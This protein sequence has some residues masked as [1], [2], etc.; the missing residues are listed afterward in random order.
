[1][2]KI[3]LGF[4]K[5]TNT[6]LLLFADNVVLKIS[7]QNNFP[8]IYPDV[9]TGIKARD[10]F[11]DAL[12]AAQNGGRLEIAN[13]NLKRKELEKVLKLWGSHIEDVSNGNEI[14]ILDAG[15]FV[16]QTS[17]AGKSP[18]PPQNVRL[19]DG[20]LQGD[21][22]A[23]CKKVSN[24][25]SYELRHRQANETEWTIAPIA[26]KTTIELK[27]VAAPGTIIWVQ[28]RAS[29]SHGYSD[30]SDPATIMVR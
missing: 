3:K 28:I 11:R 5:Y 19:V 10:A 15:Y 6:D 29:N 12:V 24:A 26:Y 8:N 27:N 4:S 25:I 14:T 30:W 1:M 22:K 16:Q 20:A 23:R 7:T 18:T 21:V 2:A 13:R 9:T 17:I